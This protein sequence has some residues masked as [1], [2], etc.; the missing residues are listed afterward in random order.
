MPNFCIGAAAVAVGDWKTGS[1]PLNVPRELAYAS[2]N[3]VR[4]AD[5]D[6]DFAYEMKVDHGFTQ[7]L[8][9]TL[10]SLSAYPVLPVMLNCAAPPLPSFRRVRLLGEALGR[11]ARSS[12]RRVLFIGSG[13]LSHDPPIPRLEGADESQRELMVNGRNASLELRAIRE[14]RVVT[15]A[16]D[17][18]AGSKDFRAPNPEWDRNVIRLL[19][20]RNLSEVDSWTDKAVG[21]VGGCGAHE[22]RTWI[23]A[24]AALSAASDNSYQTTL[25]YYEVVPQW[26]T[27]MGI[28]RAS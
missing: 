16:L 3:A 11:F 13:G 6:V 12:G 2:C 25:E 18:S 8:E 28:V 7:V 20:S 19:S 14:N 10:G 24:F 15:A 21:E 22:V 5:I 26:M 1:G 17:F 9:L 27:G 23:A 4:A